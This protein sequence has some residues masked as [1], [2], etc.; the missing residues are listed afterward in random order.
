MCMIVPVYD[1][2]SMS[3]VEFIDTVVLLQNCS[4]QVLHLYVAI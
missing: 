3:D 4:R 1:C 2:G